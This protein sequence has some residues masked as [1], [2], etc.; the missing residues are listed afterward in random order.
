MI[1]VILILGSVIEV[2]GDYRQYKFVKEHSSIRE[3]SYD[4]ILI[5][6]ADYITSS[7]YSLGSYS[8]HIRYLYKQRNPIHPKLIIDPFFMNVE[9]VKLL[10][11]MALVLQ[12]I[13]YSSTKRPGQGFSLTCLGL[14]LVNIIIGVLVSVWALS[15][16]YTVNA[17]DAFGWLWVFNQQ[18]KWFKWYP[19]VAMN[20][21]Y[22]SCSNL[23]YWAIT[24][25]TIGMCVIGLGQLLMFKY[26]NWYDIPVNYY[27]LWMTMV[28]I[29]PIIGL[30]LQKMYIYRYNNYSVIN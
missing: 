29:P 22:G 2:F 14:I 11:S 6:L 16:K 20:W 28:I 9:F 8:S 24:A 10:L 4:T 13:K 25:K 5:N 12:L 19:Q 15:R 30:Q 21:Q 3:I 7:I 23:D 26:V 17:L 1:Q 18:M 27:S